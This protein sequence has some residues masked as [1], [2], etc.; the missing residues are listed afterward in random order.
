MSDANAKSLFATIRQCYVTYKT[1]RAG[2]A[3][4]FRNVC[5]F[6]LPQQWDMIVMANMADA[7][8]TA[9]TPLSYGRSIMGG[10]PVSLVPH[11]EQTGFYV[12]DGD[13]KRQRI[14]ETFS[15]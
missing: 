6:M 7:W 4:D 14:G 5:I 15:E 8:F 13:G 9:P 10:I 1:G 3:I 2:L 11:T 12:D